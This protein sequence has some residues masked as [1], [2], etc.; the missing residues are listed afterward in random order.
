MTG[1]PYQQ[2]YPSTYV[3]LDALFEDGTMPADPTAVTGPTR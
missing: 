3:T 2:G 1:V